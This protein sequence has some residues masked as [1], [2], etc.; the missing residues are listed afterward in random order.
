M[1]PT[2]LNVN[3]AKSLLRAMADASG[4]K[5]DVTVSAE[6][7]SRQHALGLSGDDRS[8]AEGYLTEQGWLDLTVGAQGGRTLTQSG[9]DVAHKVRP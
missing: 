2:M 4:W 1:K 6:D 7:A 9:L 8:D 5:V 3:R